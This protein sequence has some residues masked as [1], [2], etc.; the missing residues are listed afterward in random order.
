PL[1]G[2]AAPGAVIMPTWSDRFGG[3]LRDIDVGYL[4]DFIESQRF[5]LVP[6]SVTSTGQPALPEAFASATPA[7]PVTAGAVIANPTPGPAGSNI[8]SI[9]T[10]A[11]PFKQGD[12]A[13]GKEVFSTKGCVGCHTIEGLQGAVG[14]VGPNLTH[15]AGQP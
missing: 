15:I 14:T 13:A 11:Q 4:V 6:K 2:V 12:A 5:D 8:V 9:S 7:P 1:G 10:G 3:P